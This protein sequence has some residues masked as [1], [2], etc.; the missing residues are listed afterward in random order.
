MWPSFGGF[1]H[2]C[3]QRRCGV[4][5]FG[6]KNGAKC[7]E[8]VKKRKMANVFC[9]F[10]PKRKNILKKLIDK[11]GKLYYNGFTQI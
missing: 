5:D 9:S 7:F 2:K 10:C 1:V 11:S 3:K 6:N 4:A 8:I